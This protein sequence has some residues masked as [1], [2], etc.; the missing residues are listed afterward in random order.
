MKNLKKPPETPWPFPQTPFSKEGKARHRF[1]LRAP[2]PGSGVIVPLPEGEDRRVSEQERTAGK[3]KAS[4]DLFI[5][6]HQNRPA[7]DIPALLQSPC[8]GPNSYKPETT[9]K[10]I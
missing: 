6:R 3:A 10:N 1:W 9:S 4:A 7:L 2:P 5:F 8:L